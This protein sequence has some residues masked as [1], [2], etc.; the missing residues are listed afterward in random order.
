VQSALLGSRGWA[1]WLGQSE[2][3]RYDLAASRPGAVRLG[4]V[5]PK[6]VLHLA[7]GGLEKASAAFTADRGRAPAPPSWAYLP[8]ID[9]INSGEG[10]AAPCG[11][12][13]TGGAAVGRYPGDRETG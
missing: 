3:G 2:L 11:G 10:E 13:F 4:V 5:A 1:A 7:G 9:R 8:W 12:G 6:L